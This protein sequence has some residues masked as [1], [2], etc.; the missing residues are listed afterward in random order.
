[1]LKNT[2]E[3]D[4]E[5]RLGEHKEGRFKFSPTSG[6]LAAGDKAAG[7]QTES[8]ARLVPVD[9]KSAQTAGAGSFGFTGGKDSVVISIDFTS[10][11]TGEFTETY[12]WFL[13]GSQEPLTLTFRGK[14]IGP[15]FAFEEK[16]IN[17]G[18][19]SYGFHHE[20]VLN[21]VNTSQVS[22]TLRRLCS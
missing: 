13:T 17:F 6:S 1:M 12:D 14:V 19:V 4:C 7:A 11:T 10:S 2:G 16:E 18:V 9:A 8:K 20:K 21:L 15:T 5:Y 3:I 22:C